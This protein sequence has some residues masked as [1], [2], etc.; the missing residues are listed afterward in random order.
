PL[1]ARPSF[2]GTPSLLCSCTSLCLLSCISSLLP[3]P[4]TH[5]AQMPPLSSLPPSYIP[6]LLLLLLRTAPLLFPSLLS[7]PSH[8]L[9]PASSSLFPSLSASSIPL[10]RL[11]HN[12]LRHPNSPSART[13]S[14]SSLLLPSPSTSCRSPLLTPLPLPLATL[15]PL[16]HLLFHLPPS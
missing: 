15:V 16:A 4:R 10:H 13:H 2:P 5:P 1:P 12:A 9:H 6:C 11:P 14:S 3:P 7:L 8:L